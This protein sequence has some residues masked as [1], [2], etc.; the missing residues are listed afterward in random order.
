M[1][2]DVLLDREYDRWSYNCLHFAGDCWAH[3]TGDDRLSRVRES[4][5]AEQG[6]VSLFRGMTR[7]KEA[8]AQPS[9]VLME[10]LEGRLHIGVCWR[11]RLLHINEAGCQFLPVEA[12]DALYKNMRFYS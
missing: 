6:L 7:S 12:L 10:T 5:L 2:I 3:L 4:H 11:R 1:S 8:T 9:I